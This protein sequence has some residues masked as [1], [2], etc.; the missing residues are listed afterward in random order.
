[1]YSSTYLPDMSAYFFSPPPLSL[2]LNYPSTSSLLFYLRCERDYVHLYSQLESE[3]D[4]LLE[5]KITGP[6]CGS[7]RDNLPKMVV[8]TN[9]IL[10]I[11]FHSNDA[12]TNKGFNGTWE[13]INGGML[14]YAI[15]SDPII[16]RISLRR[17]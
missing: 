14:V 15:T 8:S 7:Q 16:F 11:W 1:M 17:D 13:F 10:V 2:S 12:T 9:H 4:D 5:A 6:F 3:K